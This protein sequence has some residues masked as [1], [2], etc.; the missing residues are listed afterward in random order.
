[1][2]KLVI[3]A[4][5]AL[6]VALSATS[7]L[8]EGIEKRF[9]VTGRLGFLVPSDS[10]L[11]DF[12][13]ETDV[14]FMFGGG[15]IYG[16]NKNIALEF[17]ISHSWFD[18]NLPSGPGTGQFSVTYIALGGQYRFAELYPKLT[19]YAG[20]GLDI[21]LPDHDNG[22]VDTVVGL[23]ISGGADYFFTHN[24][25]ATAELKA[26]LAPDADIK[27]TGGPGGHFDPTNLSGS[28]GVRYF[29]W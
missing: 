7:V 23:C 17:D 16:L 5:I 27:Q 11:N 13:L 9:G 20:A 29:F 26:V 18:S 10:D 1:M 2:K 3:F 25:A 8:A 12:K 15:L 28:I 19:P 6:A 21:I 24:I 14:G 22:N 4:S